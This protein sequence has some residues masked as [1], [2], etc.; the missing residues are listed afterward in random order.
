MIGQRLGPYHV[1]EKLGEG[2]MGE[3][4]RA[5]DTR[6]G[7]EVAIKVLP[8][9]VAADPDRRARFE[10]EAQAIAALSHPNILA[11]FD[12]GTHEH[13]LFAVTELLHGATLRDRLT[14]SGP[15]SVRKAIEIAIGIARGLTA[16]HAKGVVH[17]DLKPENIFLLD[18]GQVKILD[19]G[20]ARQFE[21]VAASG[22]AATMAVTDPGFMMG[23]VGYMAPEQVR[24]LGIDARTDLFALGAVLY[25]M[26]TGRRAF[27]RETAADSLSAILTQD[28]PDLSGAIAELSPVLERIVRHCL[29]KNPA[30]RFQTARDVVFALESLAG[31]MPLPSGSTAVAASPAKS[32]AKLLA[33]ALAGAAIVAAA[34]FAGRVSTS[35]TTEPTWL[36]L[37][38]PHGRFGR[39][40]MPAISPDGTQVAFWAPDEQGR[41]ALWVRRFESPDARALPGT[42]TA[43]E[44]FQP[45]WAPDGRAIAFFAEGKLKRIAL[46][47][48]VPQTLA[49]ATSPRGGSWSR[50]GRII[51]V[52][53]SAAGVYTIPESGGAPALVP[54]NDPEKRPLQYP[55]FLPDNRHFLISS[56]NGGV[57]L[58]SLDDPAS[59]T[60]SAARSRVEY[61]AGHLFFEQ[62]GGLYAQKFDP[63]RF[64]TSGVPVRVSAAVGYG[65]GSFIDRTFSVSGAGRLV[66]AEGTWLAPTELVWFDRSG[67]RL[68]RVSQASELNGFVMSPD[69]QRALAERH[70]PRTNL[71]G[72]WVLD[73][74]AGTEARIAQAPGESIELTPMWSADETRVFFSTL[75]GIFVRQV[76]G[77]QIT[78][79][80]EQDRTVWLSDRSADGK[81]LVFEKG[82]PATQ[83]DIWVLALGSTPAARS[84]MATNY[85]E[86]QGTISPDVRAIAYVSEESGRR[87]VYV[88]TFPEPQA[89]VPVSVGGG[90]LPEW[91]PDGRELF[92]VAPNQTLVAVTIDTTATPVRAGRPVRLFQL[93]PVGEFA[94][95][96]QYHA[97]LQGDRFLVN[98]RLPNEPDAP[99]TV[100]LNWPAVL[101]K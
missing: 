93:P 42:G 25:E 94:N 70:D 61:A 88:D 79:L 1:L 66:F 99:V 64:E 10:R 8:E 44:P 34:W 54:I 55:H 5:R 3:V 96:H 26:L 30:E 56:T 67:R 17:R 33:A 47:Q 22:G 46:D 62:D 27:A 53:V 86:T 19:F 38:P 50:D 69:R 28:P 89:K 82:D 29:E 45:F 9:S 31:P 68:E 76:R 60:V 77:G 57:L 37:R 63:S 49:D 43:G 90:S 36:S 73:L 35:A 78:R 59:R 23:T 20:L 65:F 14:E 80:L 15:L 92:Y 75:R 21:G 4:Y 48:G 84:Y 85:N 97:S 72:P 13:S 95:R 101:P 32:G 58:C 39:H 51:Y 71:T 40:P 41:T 83:Q 98:A 24:G 16:A 81:Y 91:R 52:P 87:E 18:D 100:I 12:T 74:A 6:L 7:R 2:G 11:I